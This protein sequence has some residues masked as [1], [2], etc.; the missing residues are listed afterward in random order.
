MLR[1]FKSFLFILIEILIFYCRNDWWYSA[2][3]LFGGL[4]RVVQGGQHLVRG[5]GRRRGGRRVGQPR[6]TEPDGGR[7]QRLRLRVPI[8][9]KS[10]YLSLVIRGLTLL[11]LLLLHFKT[12]DVLTTHKR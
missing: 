1:F 8:I 4:D 7:D 9:D 11:C 3:R 2:V 5:G 10:V 12:R 6:G